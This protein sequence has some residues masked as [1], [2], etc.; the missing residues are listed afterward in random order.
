MEAFNDYELD[1]GELGDV[2]SSAG[3]HD[4]EAERSVLAMLLK[5][6]KLF[7]ELEEQLEAADFYTQRHALIFK[8]LYDL[9]ER[10][11]KKADVVTVRNTL[12]DASELESAGGKEYLIELDSYADYALNFA[13]HVAIV[14][15]KATLRKLEL[16]VRKIAE[17]IR[18]REGRSC[19]DQLDAAESS[20]FELA[21]QYHGKSRDSTRKLGAMVKP[22]TEQI[23]RLGELRRQGLKPL[24]GLATHYPLLDSMTS[25]LQ[26][27]D[28]VV[29]AARPSVGKTSFALD[30]LRQVCQHKTVAPGDDA[31]S[32]KQAAVLFS[33]EMST[34]QITQ[35]MISVEARIDQHHMRTGKMSGAKE[36]GRFAEATEKLKE[37]PLWVEDTPLLNIIEMRS[38]VRRI[39]RAAE[40]DG[41]ELKLIV[42][43]YLQLMDVPANAASDNRATEVA[44]ISRGLK[45]LARE[46][47]LP[48]LALSQLS[49]KVE[50]RKSARPQLSDLRESGAIEQDADV[51]MFLSRAEQPRGDDGYHEA[52]ATG[53][54][55]VELYVGKHRNGPTGSID[56]EFDK[57]Y[58]HFEEL[59]RAGYD[60]SDEPPPGTDS[61][62]V[63]DYRFN[64]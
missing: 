55:K 49:R 9:C 15:D 8:T 17:G 43:D 28:L 38:R 3:A 42:V 7:S 59:G 27:S 22:V 24:T 45:G 58:T 25:G 61:G 32:K 26:P 13:E 34:E 47:K 53:R 1:E 37:W 52:S 16:N 31:P 50:D 19:A 14:R 57:R 30:I 60:S 46:M 12:A 21:N 44:Q 56:F 39:V 2:H 33:L 29:L 35:R 63:D 36:W 23:E 11:G 10:Q 5:N 6:N 54:D 51:I 4:E 62:D 41:A 64:S 18:R 48:V 40:E 20:I